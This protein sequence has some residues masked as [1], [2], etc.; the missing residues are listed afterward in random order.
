MIKNKAYLVIVI[1]S[2]L[3]TQQTHT[4]DGNARRH[5]VPRELPEID[6]S[7]PDVMSEIG[8]SVITYH[9]NRFVEKFLN[10]IGQTTT[11][12]D[13]RSEDVREPICMSIQVK[14]GHYHICD[15]DVCMS[16]GNVHECVAI[17]MRHVNPNLVAL[18]H[19]YQK[20]DEDFIELDKFLSEVKNK[21]DQLQI[22]ISDVAICL[23]SSYVSSNF[24]IIER[25]MQDKNFNISLCHVR[26]RA[27]LAN[28]L[29]VKSTDTV[30]SPGRLILASPSAFKIYQYNYN[31]P[32][33]YDSDLPHDDEDCVIS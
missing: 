23:V 33:K 24:V 32:G 5:Q 14:A 13:E 9:D 7:N 26:P 1:A 29:Y 11:A 8:G 17:A 19:Y 30:T 16:T 3:L 4:M 20:A 15:K 10:L 27:Y 22:N 28:G 18:Y 21:A 31:D 12:L 25:A 6:Q 2:L